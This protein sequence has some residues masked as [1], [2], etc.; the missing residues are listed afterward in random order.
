MVAQISGVMSGPWDPFRDQKVKTTWSETSQIILHVSPTAQGH[1]QIHPL[2][3]LQD[4]REEVLLALRLVEI[5]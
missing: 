4:I 2:A 3:S 5:V 1:H